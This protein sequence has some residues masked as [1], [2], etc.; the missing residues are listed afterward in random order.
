MKELSLEHMGKLEG[1]NVD[2]YGIVCGALS[3][4][5]FMFDDVE[6]VEAA[7]VGYGCI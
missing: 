5:W 4:A 7:M 6:G 1:G 3:G 2:W